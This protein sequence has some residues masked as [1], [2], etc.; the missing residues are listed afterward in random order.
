MNQFIGEV[1]LSTTEIADPQFHVTESA[2]E[3]WW[4][5]CGGGGVVMVVM[6]W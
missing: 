2:V 3:W 5:W 4:W 1:K 6:G